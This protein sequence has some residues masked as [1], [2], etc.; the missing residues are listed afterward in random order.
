MPNKIIERGKQARLQGLS[1]SENPYHAGSRER[2]LWY[3]GWCEGNLIDF[4]NQPTSYA[5]EQ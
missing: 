2:R 4:L 5:I 1:L 3:L